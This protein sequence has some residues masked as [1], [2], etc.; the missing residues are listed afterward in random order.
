MTTQ[1]TYQ[2]RMD[3]GFVG[4]VA[5]QRLKNIV[6]YLAEDATLEAGLAVIQGTNDNQCAVGAAGVFLGITTRD[7][8]LAPNRTVADQDKYVQNGNVN[9]LDFGAV[10]VETLAICA[11]GNPVYRTAAGALTPTSTSNTLIAGARFLDSGAANDI[12]RITLK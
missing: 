7:P 2:N 9:V 10:Y 8:T 11:A 5:D 3:K 1:T 4:Q 6:T 12:V